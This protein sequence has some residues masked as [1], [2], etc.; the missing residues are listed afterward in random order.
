[1]FNRAVRK[2][3]SRN[4]G[5]VA[6]AAMFACAGGLLLADSALAEYHQVHGTHSSA[7]VGRDCGSRGGDF[8]KDKDGGY[9]CIL[10]DGGTLTSVECTAKG[11]CACQ[12][13]QCA[14]VVKRGI[15]GLR[16]PAS[17][18]TASAVARTTNNKHPIIN[19]HPI[20]NANQPAVV[21][22]S[23]GHSGG[24]KH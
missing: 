14:A 22:H 8:Y 20:T 7:E 17:A 4:L 2:L 24:T 18:G 15:K 1:M 12:G 16:P 9:G 13:P 3:P 6:F 23:G 21:Q 11:S 19:I 5:R 10:N